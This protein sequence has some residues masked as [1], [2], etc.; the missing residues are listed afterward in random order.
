MVVGRGFGKEI[1]YSVAGM[2]SDYEYR[3]RL[4]QLSKPDP[5]IAAR[6]ATRSGALAKLETDLGSDAWEERYGTLL[7]HDQPDCGYLLAVAA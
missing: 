3:R 4:R 5:R 2:P 6:I 1:G 7:T